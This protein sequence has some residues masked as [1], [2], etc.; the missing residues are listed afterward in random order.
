MGHAPSRYNRQILKPV[1]PIV[2]GIQSIHVLPFITDSGVHSLEELAKMPSIIANCFRLN[3]HTHRPSHGL[4]V[5]IFRYP[6][7]GSQS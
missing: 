1:V 4:F 5:M 2:A 6:H 7:E 3:R